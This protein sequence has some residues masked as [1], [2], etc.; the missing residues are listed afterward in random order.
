MR[1]RMLQTKDQREGDASTRL[2]KGALVN[3]SDE[4]AEQLLAADEAELDLDEVIGTA[5]PRLE[6]VDETGTHLIVQVTVALSPDP[7]AG[8]AEPGTSVVKLTSAT[9]VDV[10]A[11]PAERGRY[12][13]APA[14]WQ[15]VKGPRVGTV[16][17]M[18]QRTRYS[19]RTQTLSIPATVTPAASG[20]GV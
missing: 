9:G 10:V 6:I 18:A 19:S 17:F 12:A 5:T 16:V 1:V 8:D 14:E 3:V 13:P 20:Q 7:E 11:S 15:F 2:E 4:L